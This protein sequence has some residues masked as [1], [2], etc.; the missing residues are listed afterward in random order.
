M[1]RILIVLLLAA[2]SA[3]AE[4]LPKRLWKASVVVLAGAAAVDIVTSQHRYELNS[5][6][7]G[8]DGTLGARG[9]SIKIGCEQESG[10]D[11]GFG[12]IWW[13]SGFIRASSIGALPQTPRGIPLRPRP[14]SLHLHLSER[15]SPSRVRSAAQNRRALDRSGPFRTAHLEKGKGA[16]AKPSLRPA[17]LADGAWYAGHHA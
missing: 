9:V 17:P 14:L 16:T 1:K 8:P 6:L 4:S 11:H 15:S 7:R 13:A 3:C 2:V 12:G 5:L 10:V